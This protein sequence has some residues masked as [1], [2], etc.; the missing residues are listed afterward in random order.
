MI[1]LLIGNWGYYFM[2]QIKL[3]MLPQV[4]DPTTNTCVTTCAAN[5][6][7]STNTQP[8]VCQACSDS[9]KV[10]DSLTGNC[11][12]PPASYLDPV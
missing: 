9:G 8:T 7:Y 3:V 5:L 1:A 2:K 10:F 4:L 11:D 12:C 6:Y